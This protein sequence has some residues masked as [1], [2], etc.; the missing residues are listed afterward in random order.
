MVLK[1]KDLSVRYLDTFCIKAHIR[2]AFD[3]ALDQTA[4]LE[5][6]KDLIRVCIVCISEGLDGG[7]GGLVFTIH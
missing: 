7:G 2:L 6:L 1:L 4:A 3:K 5:L